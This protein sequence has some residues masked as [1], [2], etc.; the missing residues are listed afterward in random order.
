MKSKN[1]PLRFIFHTLGV[2]P[3]E[4]HFH[5]Q[6]DILREVRFVGGGCPGNAQL[7]S[8]FLRGKPLEEV[9]ELLREI[10]CR[11]G[12]SCPDQLAKAI[13]AAKDG[14]LD[15]ARSFRVYADPL[16][17]DCI[18]LIG[19][20]GGRND[21]LENLIHHIHKEEVET[22]YCLGNLTGDS[23]NNKEILARLRGEGI[24]AIQGELDFRY[25]QSEEPNDLPS[26]EHKERDYLMRLPQLISFK[27][28]TKAGVAFFGQ[29]LQGLPGYSDFEPFALEMNMVCNLRQYMVSTSS[30]WIW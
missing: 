20:L 24:L 7:V 11:N 16:A 28:G 6:E 4:I 26:L 18:G 15:P 17:R 10:D 13:I 12:T 29:Y 30:L 21:I 14:S 1:A 19:D 23:P 3:P 27:M 22:I 8:R 5:I 25:A 9:L 2:C